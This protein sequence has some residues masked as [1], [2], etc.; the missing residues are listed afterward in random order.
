MISHLGRD[1]LGRQRHAPG[2]AFKAI[3]GTV[4]ATCIGEGGTSTGAFHEA[5]N[6]A[7]VEKLPLVLVVAN[8]Q[9]AYSTPSQP[10]VRL[11]RLVDSARLRRGRSHR[12]WNRSGRVPEGLGR[13][14]RARARNGGGPQL[15]DRALAAALRPWRARRRQLRGSTAQA[16]A[17]WAAIV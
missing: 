10:A 4:G 15:V 11:P 5:L 14:G 7:A 2:A 8:N 9:Y 12:G 13:R 3:T 16:I 17:A 6:Q 1:D